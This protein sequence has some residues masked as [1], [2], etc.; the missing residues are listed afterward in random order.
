MSTRRKEKWGR[1]APFTATAIADG[2]KN[3]PALGGQVP[4]IIAKGD[5]LTVP[6]IYS[7]SADVALA[8]DR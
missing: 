6:K 4:Y 5:I 8:A 2:I 3:G 7:V 1:S